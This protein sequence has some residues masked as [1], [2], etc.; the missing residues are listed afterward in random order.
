[1]TRNSYWASFGKKPALSEHDYKVYDKYI[2][3]VYM[4]KIT[5]EARAETATYNE[6]S[7]KK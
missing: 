2:L 3:G 1:M 4:N 6:R 7:E 5:T